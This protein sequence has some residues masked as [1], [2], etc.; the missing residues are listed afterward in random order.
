M[1]SLN[2]IKH[3]WPDLDKFIYTP[4]IKVSIAF[5][6][7]TK[8]VIKFENNPKSFI[9]LSKTIDDACENIGD[10]NQTKKGADSFCWN[11]SRYG[12]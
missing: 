4:Q 12:C 6:N 11:D 2:L 1:F 7:T 3:H 8:L 5:I 10:Y 9:D